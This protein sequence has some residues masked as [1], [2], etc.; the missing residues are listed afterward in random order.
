MQPVSFKVIKNKILHKLFLI[1]S[2]LLLIQCTNSE[3]K[4]STQLPHQAEQASAM[5]V[6]Q[7]ASIPNITKDTI[8]K[9]S[10]TADYI[11]GKINPQ[12]HPDFKE[13][14]TKHASAKGMYLRKDAY[15]AFI[16]MFDA[17]Q[18]DGIK[19]VIRSATRPFNHQKRIWEGKWTGARLVKGRNLSKT[20]A[21]HNDRALKILEYSSMPGTSRHHWGTDM[22][23][24]AF[25]NSY[26][27]KGQGKKEYDW[28]I[29][30]APT[31]GFC[32]PYTSKKEGRTGYEEEKW[33]WSYLP[34]STQLTDTA[35][36]IL[37]DSM[38]TGFKGSHTASDIEV[39]KNYV[40]GINGACRH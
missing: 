6:A 36:D 38:I 14:S 8:V 32:Q 29:A 11:M 23:F 30:N 31:Y 12:N 34:I 19:L 27:E 9:K 4:T 20:T 2:I 3:P 39:V 7:D 28:L 15:A 21:D 18:K 33:H 17:A 1:S 22:D 35:A 37:K 40:L 26:F 13:L 24:N 5:L 25:V 10:F 16:K